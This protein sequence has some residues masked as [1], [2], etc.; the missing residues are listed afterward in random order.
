L[1]FIERAQKAEYHCALPH[2]LKIAC[3]RPADPYEDV[4]GREQRISIRNESRARFAVIIIGARG[5]Q[6]RA[7]FDRN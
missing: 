7:A 3:G 4:S 1:R 5:A 2:F 6:A